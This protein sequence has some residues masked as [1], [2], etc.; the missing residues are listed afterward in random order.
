MAAPTTGARGGRGSTRRRAPRRGTPRRAV[1]HRRVA[2]TSGAILVVFGIYAGRLVELQAI[3]ADALAATA[4]EQRLI[5][6]ALP[7]L[8]GDII[9][10][11]GALLATTDPRVTITADQTLVAGY[12]DR[13]DKRKAGPRALAARLAPVIGADVAVIA[14]TLTGDARY[15]VVARDITPEVWR[16]VAALRLQGIFSERTTVRDYPAGRVA[17]NVVGFVGS[18]GAG[19]AG[20]ELGHDSHLSGVDGWAQYERSG[21]SRGYREI[22]G[23]AATGQD[24]VD[25][26]DVTLTLDRD[27]QWQAEQA[28]S[29]AVAASGAQ[30][31]SVIAMTVTGDVLAMADVPGY[32][33]NDVDRAVEA[34]L[35]NRA[36]NDV[37][38]P[39]STSK[40]ITI[41]GA[42]QDGLAVPTTPFTVPD[43]IDRGGRTFNDS[44]SHPPQ[45]L[46]LTGVLAESSNTGTIMSTEQMTPQRLHEWFA[47]FG[48][49]RVSGIGLP[50]ESAGLLPPAADWS[51]SQQYTVRFGQGVSVTA[52]Q[53]ASV[54]QTIANDGVRVPP[55]MVVGTTTPDGSFTPTPTRQAEPVLA[56]DTAVKLQRMLESAVSDEG[57]GSAAVVP[58][59]RVAGKT[60]TAQRYDESCGGYCGYTASFVGFAPA[61]DPQ[62]IV[63]VAVQDPTR[64]IYGGT[65]AAPVFKSVM[66]AALADLRVAPSVSPP[67][68]YPVSW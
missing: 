66:T 18:D 44:H 29:R 55:R 9:D 2:I 32:D 26:D 53:M 22:P 61:E 23:G 34:N 35:G 43:R 16:Q 7:A 38:E 14:A 57:T 56:A 4:L 62:I 41:A 12:V 47:A 45:Q 36:I 46:T 65:T 6:H 1:H 52:L 5:D 15:T 24:P 8:R 58:G 20:V 37:F 50:G 59:Y 30:S 49:G 17:A 3:D 25:G 13:D 63:A 64:G 67:E 42:L 11:D 51:A 39:G 48:Y 60:G 21:E 19:L 68:L 28:A 10:R 31:A 27:L 54:F 33:P 40:V